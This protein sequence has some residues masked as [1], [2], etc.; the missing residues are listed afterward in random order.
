[1]AIIAE[2]QNT[3]DLERGGA[4]AAELDGIYTYMLSRLLDAIVQQ[5]AQPIDEVRRMLETLRDA[6]QQ[7]A[8]QPPPPAPGRSAAMTSDDLARLIEQYRA[9]LDAE[10]NLLRQLA[11]V[12]RAPARGHR[13]SGDFAAFDDAA[14]ERDRSCG[15]W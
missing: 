10:L 8:A 2:L 12:V 14:D 1:M 15:A 13:V 4:I 7:I 9:G 5:D 3:L 11:D 6:W